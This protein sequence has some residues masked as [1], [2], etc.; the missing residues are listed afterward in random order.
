MDKVQKTAF[1]SPS[2]EPFRL[3]SKRISLHAFGMLIVLL[4]KFLTIS[5]EL[6]VTFLWL[7]IVMEKSLQVKIMTTLASLVW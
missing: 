2:S 7:L 5:Y 6:T 1:N 4:Y 3:H